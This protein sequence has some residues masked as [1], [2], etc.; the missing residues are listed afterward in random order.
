[1]FVLTAYKSLIYPKSDYSLPVYALIGY[2]R[3]NESKSVSQIRK[4]I[5]KTY[6]NLVGITDRSIENIYK[7]VQVC[8]RQNQKDL[9]NIKNVYT[10]LPKHQKPLHPM[11]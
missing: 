8:L 4:Y 2:H 3:L 11:A 6:P 7:R 9:L 5:E 10:Q 1:M